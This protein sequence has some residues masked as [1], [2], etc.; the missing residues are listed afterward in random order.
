MSD[1]ELQVARSEELLKNWPTSDSCLGCA[2]CSKLF[3][4]GDG[5][6]CPFCGSIA[7]WNVGD[8]LSGIDTKL[9]PRALLDARTRAFAARRTE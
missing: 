7:I 3:K 1:E 6:A 5:N 8:F 2:E 4:L 9:V